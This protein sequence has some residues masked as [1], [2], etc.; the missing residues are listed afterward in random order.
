VTTFCDNDALRNNWFVV[1]L[2]TDI[3]EQPR[4]ISLLGDRF[5]I[6]RSADGELVA[7]EDRCPH[8]EAPLSAGSVKEGT[9]T[10]RY[11]GWTFGDQGRCLSVPSASKTSQVPVRAHLTTLQVTEKYGLVWLCPGVTTSEVPVV[12]EDSDPSF[13]RFNTPIQQWAASAT[14]M[15]DN[16]LDTAHFAFVHDVSIG[17]GINPR[18]ATFDVQPLDD[19]FTGYIYDVLVANPE[20][21]HSTLG[22]SATASLVHMTTGFA[23]PFIVRGTM[24]FPN[25]VRQVLMLSSTPVDD[26]NSLFTFAIWRNDDE[27]E[28]E[29]VNFELQIDAEDQLMV[30]ML[31]GPLPLEGGRLVS[32]RSDKGSEV[33]R[34]ELVRLL[35][36]NVPRQP[37]K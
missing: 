18:V 30:E 34:R 19:W 21:A 6:W 9:L 16:F 8:R 14:R 31:D 26:L 1:A 37:A 5:V 17:S 27:P 13:H 10:C 11:H 29:I 20:E 7:A 24:Q 22:D 32:V 2:V 3:G 36:S 23:L 28:A 12:V 15:V 25:G 4:A 35:V 33:W